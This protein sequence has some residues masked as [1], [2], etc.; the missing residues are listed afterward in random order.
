MRLF[1][2]RHLLKVT[3]SKGNFS[4]LLSRLGHVIL[5]LQN[6]DDGRENQPTLKVKIVFITQKRGFFVCQVIIEVFGTN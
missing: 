1:F 6:V 5:R 4:L 2:K 3:N